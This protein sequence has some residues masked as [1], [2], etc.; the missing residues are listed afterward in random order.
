MVVGETVGVKTGKPTIE[1]VTLLDI[2][3]RHPV[4]TFTA[5]MVYVPPAVKLPKSKLA[6]VP[7]T[8]VTGTPALYNV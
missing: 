5:L 8:V 2:S 4:A 1:I 3:L 7:C 6:P